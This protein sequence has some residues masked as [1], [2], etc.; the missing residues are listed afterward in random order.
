MQTTA[1]FRTLVQVAGIDA[2]HG[3]LW[4]K[5]LG[6]ARWS[7][8]RSWRQTAAQAWHLL[9]ANPGG[10]LPMGSLEETL[11]AALASLVVCVGKVSRSTPIV[12]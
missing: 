6:Q 8:S 3:A 1:M 12:G 9:L 11:D 7:T 5:A 10:V 4:W 2:H